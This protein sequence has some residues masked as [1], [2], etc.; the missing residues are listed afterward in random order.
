MIKS[1]KVEM[2]VKVTDINRLHKKIKRLD[3]ANDMRHEFIQ[4]HF[5]KNI[6]VK[7]KKNKE[8]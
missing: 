6:A 8:N 2:K 3:E 1:L 5:K 4:T 7:E